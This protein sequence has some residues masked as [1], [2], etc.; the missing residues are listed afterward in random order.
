MSPRLVFW[1]LR[2]TPFVHPDHTVKHASSFPY[3]KK[4]SPRVQVTGE[5]AF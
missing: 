1:A 2:G 4:A 3:A 5:D